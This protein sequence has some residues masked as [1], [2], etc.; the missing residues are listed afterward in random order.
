LDKYPQKRIAVIAHRQELITQARDKLLNVWPEATRHIGLACAGVGQVDVNKPV[1]IGSVQ[2]LDRRELSPFDF[3]IVDECH[4]IPPLEDGSQYHNIIKWNWDKKPALRVL[5]VTATPFR[6]GHGYIYGSNCKPGK[7][8]LFPRLDYSI[9]MKTLVDQGYLVRWR[10]KRTVDIQQ[11]LK[12]VSKARGDY[13]IRALSSLMSKDIHIQSA[14][15]AYEEYGEE[16]QKVVVFAVTIEHAKLL[17]AAFKARGYSA[18]AVHSQLSSEIRRI[19]LN[20]F[21]KKNTQFLINVGILTEGWDSPIVDEIIMCRPTMSPGL[22]VQMV[23]RGMRV[24]P[25]KNN[26]LV[27]DLADNFERHG[28]PANPRVVVGKEATGEPILKCC[29]ECFEMAYA[30]QKFCINCGYQFYSNNIA[31][32]E[33][34]VVKPVLIEVGNKNISSEQQVLDWGVYE[35]LSIKGNRLLCLW[36]KIGGYRYPIKSY[37]DI[38]GSCGFDY[39]LSKARRLWRLLNGNINEPP[40]SIYEALVRKTELR[41]PQIVHLF[42]DKNDFVKVKEFEV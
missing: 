18:V 39:P 34:K 2:T 20:D 19:Y 9:S 40:R 38:A 35:H 28:D 5:G 36:L 42:K 37:L 22:F 16:R 32:R 12:D 6:L 8:N 11:E 17:E 10:A 25:D 23:G 15:N 26:L 13:D 30:A 31:E 29:P 14:V 1:V 21:E 3:L 41:I 27:L 33:S 7:K 4:H 24:F